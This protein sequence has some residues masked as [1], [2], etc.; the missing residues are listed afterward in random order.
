MTQGRF[1]RQGFPQGPLDAEHLARQTGGDA[2]LAAEV[3]AL[4]AGQ[5]RDVLGALDAMPVAA[6]PAAMHKLKGSA[7]GVGASLVAERA[8]ALEEEPGSVAARRSLREAAEGTLR[9][10]SP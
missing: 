9:A 6:V 4:F 8:A 2:A 5:L 1:H 3:L 10:I 7:R